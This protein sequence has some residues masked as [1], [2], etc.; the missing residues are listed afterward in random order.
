MLISEA[1]LAGAGNLYLFFPRNFYVAFLMLRRFLDLPNKK[2]M[3]IPEEFYSVWIDILSNYDFSY[4]ELDSKTDFV[5][6]SPDK[7]SFSPK[8]PSKRHFFLY[9]NPEN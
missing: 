2:C 6:F 1:E 9:Q 8:V 3:I 4:I 7:N 5:Q